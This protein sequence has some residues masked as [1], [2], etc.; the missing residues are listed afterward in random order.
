MQKLVY[1][2]PV[3]EKGFSANVFWERRSNDERL[4]ETGSVEF[5][6]TRDVE[7]QKGL[8]RVVGWNLFSPL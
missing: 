1:I 6:L 3:Y 4:Q 8:I 7:I 2:D 5:P